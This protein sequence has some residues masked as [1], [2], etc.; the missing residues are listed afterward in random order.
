M[1]VPRGERTTYTKEFKLSV[2]YKMMSK[3]FK[4]SDICKE[5]GIPRQT[6]HR[7]LKEFKEG[8][9]SAFDGKGVTPGE[10]LNKLKKQLKDLEMENEIL[11]KATAYFAK[12]NQ[13]K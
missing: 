8:G 11:K 3:E 13:N 4:T 7:W 9:E 5:Y 10:D 12:Q 6:A 1:I 2:V